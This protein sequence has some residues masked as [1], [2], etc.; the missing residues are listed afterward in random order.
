MPTYDYKT[1]TCTGWITKCKQWIKVLSLNHRL[2]V[3]VIDHVWLDWGLRPLMCVCSKVPQPLCFT[4][5][6]LQGHTLSSK[7]V[8]C[9]LYNWC[10]TWVSSADVVAARDQGLCAS[11]C[12]NNPLIVPLNR[13]WVGRKGAVE[14]SG[15]RRERERETKWE[16][17]K[18]RNEIQTEKKSQFFYFITHC[19]T[20]ILIYP[21]VSSFRIFFLASHSK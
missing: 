7:E 16:S 5:V 19:H 8:L 1:R 21:K 9:G 11:G 15:F 20:T 13:K 4:P 14:F 12:R 2:H 18:L 10:C 6:A 3:I 17:R